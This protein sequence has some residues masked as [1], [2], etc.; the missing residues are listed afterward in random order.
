RDGCG[1]GRGFRLVVPGHRAVQAVLLVVGA[2][3]EVEARSGTCGGAVAEADAPQAVDHQ[4]VVVRRLQ[5]AAR[6]PRRARPGE[7]VDP[8]VAEVAD[9][10][11]AAEL[12]EA[13]M[14]VS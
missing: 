11:V 8:A 6:L 5:V 1:L 12:A 14:A 4:R 3:G 2:G 13:G 9:E 7:C 10:E